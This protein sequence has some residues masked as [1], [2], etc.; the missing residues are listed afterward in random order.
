MKASEGNILQI[1]NSQKQYIVPLYQR[2]YSWRKEQHKRLWEDLVLL[3]KEH[4]GG[5]FLGSIVS[6]V[7]SASIAGTPKFLVI[8][9]QQRLTTLIILLIALRNF[10]EKSNKINSITEKFLI[11]IT[12]GEEEKYKLILTYNDKKTLIKLINRVDSNDIKKSRIM[13]AYN[14]FMEKISSNELTQQE[15]ENAISKLQI[16][17]ISLDSSIDDPQSIFE[18]LNSTGLNLSQSDLIRNF[19][20]MGLSSKEQSE[21]YQNIWLP[22]E[23]LFGYE[24]QSNFMDSFFRDY[25]TMNTGYIPTVENVYSE[26]KKFCL[27]VNLSQIDLCKE[28]Y[29]KAKNYT[30]MIF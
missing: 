13:D 10:L 29:E 25:I 8:D 20:L 2:M 1:L 9:G 14:F 18:S 24:N 3:E 6:V 16:V 21:I 22:M 4:K 12:T 17:D 26:F 7:E 19:I 27:Q 15:I 30:N 11:N 5:H 23:K 28:I